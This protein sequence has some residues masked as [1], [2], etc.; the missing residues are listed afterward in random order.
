MN[1]WKPHLRHTYHCRLSQGLVVEARPI[2]QSDAPYLVEL[3]QHL[4]ADTLYR[5]FNQHVEHVPQARVQQETEQIVH[6][7]VFKGRGWLVFADLP[8]EGHAPIG[9]M[10]WVQLNRRTGE[11]A[12][13]IRDDFQG[14]GLGRQLFQILVQEGRRAG[15]AWF[16]GYVHAGNEPVWR[17]L[18]ASGLPYI[19]HNAGSVA[20]VIIALNPQARPQEMEEELALALV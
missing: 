5:R 3:F 4:S 2:T 14:Q 8:G 1:V 20:T 17:M 18:Q 10:R 15:L 7:A 16:V 19:R 12:M 11:I 13:T 9:G 6:S